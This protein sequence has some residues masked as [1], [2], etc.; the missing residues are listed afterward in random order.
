MAS[1]DNLSEKEARYDDIFLSVLQNEG[2]IEPFLDAVF[3]FLYR[4]FI[5]F[6]RSS[7]NF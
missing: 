7:L 3:K 5:F 1:F 4:R 2:R 6:I